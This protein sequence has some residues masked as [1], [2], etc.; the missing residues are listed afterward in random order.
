MV[1]VTVYCM[2]T[3]LAMCSSMTSW[4]R[5]QDV[6]TG[7]WWACSLSF[8]NPWQRPFGPER[9]TVSNLAEAGSVRC[10]VNV[11]AGMQSKEIFERYQLVFITGPLLPT[12]LSMI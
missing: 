4:I 7:S 9:V 3:P 5:V 2:T 6:E 10:Q 12:A 11:L 1:E 8:W